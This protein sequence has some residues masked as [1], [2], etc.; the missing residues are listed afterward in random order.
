MLIEML[1]EL[2][3]IPRFLPDQHLTRAHRIDAY[4]R[5]MRREL[6]PNRNENDRG[7]HC[8]DEYHGPHRG[9][10]EGLYDA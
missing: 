7:N 8:R 6:L 5:P 10:M 3:T 2:A 4:A 1:F 9:D